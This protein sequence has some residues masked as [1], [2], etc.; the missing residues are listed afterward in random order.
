MNFPLRHIYTLIRSYLTD[1]YV[2][3]GIMTNWYPFTMME[4]G[5]P[6]GYSIGPLLLCLCINN[7]SSVLKYCNIHMFADD[8]QLYF[9]SILSDK[10]N[11]WGYKWSIGPKLGD[12]YGN[13]LIERI[14]L[15]G[16]TRDLFDNTIFYVLWYRNATPRLYI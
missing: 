2:Y 7:L 10:V 4:C 11:S 1:R 13:S 12:W 6:E 15:L 8:M 14:S 9:L 5:I 16:K 3:I